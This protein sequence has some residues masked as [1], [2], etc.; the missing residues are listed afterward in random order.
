VHVV[1]VVHV[2]HVFC[3]TGYGTAKASYWN[4]ASEP[5]VRHRQAEPEDGNPRRKGL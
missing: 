1:H 5:A 4:L 2:A 3:A